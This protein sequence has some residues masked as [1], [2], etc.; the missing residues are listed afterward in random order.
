MTVLEAAPRVTGE[1]LEIAKLLPVARIGMAED[2][3]GNQTPVALMP[4]GWRSEALG[5]LLPPKAPTFRVATPA[6]QTVAA[7]VGYVARHATASTT[8]WVDAKNQLLTAVLDDGTL[9]VPGRRVHVAKYKAELSPEFLEWTALAAKPVG[10]AAFIEFIEDHD[11]HFVNPTGARM[12]TVANMLEV[13]RGVQFKNVQRE[14]SAAADVSL[15]YET[16]TTELNEIKCPQ[17]LT[18]KIPIFRDGEKY[19]IDARLRFDLKD[20][21]LVFQLKLPE[22]AKM[23]ENAWQA[24][25][26]ELQDRLVGIEGGPV[27]KVPVFAGVLG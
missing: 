24:V 7:F 26:G 3:L 21:G 9:E 11:R 17:F 23:L 16:T 6:L 20:G 1:A 12:R 4:P 2:T 27:E 14:D 5:P 19:E 15:V 18:I 8:V 10:Q 22:V 25:V 13:K